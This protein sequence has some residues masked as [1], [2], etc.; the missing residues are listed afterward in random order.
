MI[1]TG[2]VFVTLEPGAG[3]TFS[4]AFGPFVGSPTSSFTG[5]FVVVAPTGSLCRYV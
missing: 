4:T 1:V 5:W 3:V 2:V